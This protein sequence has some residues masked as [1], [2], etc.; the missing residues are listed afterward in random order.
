MYTKTPGFREQRIAKASSIVSSCVGAGVLLCG[1]CQPHRSHLRQ[2][3]CFHPSSCQLRSASL[4]PA[5][6]LSTCT[7]HVL[8]IPQD[9]CPP[10]ST[11]HLYWTCDLYTMRP[12]SSRLKC[13]PLSPSLWADCDLY[14]MN[15]LSSCLI[16]PPPCRS[17]PPVLCSAYHKHLVLLPQLSSYLTRQSRPDF[18]FPTMN[19]PGSCL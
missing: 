12:L 8:C 3:L 15:T 18:S 1:V 16:T 4:P 11:I 2:G 7:P 9:P 10:A 5:S 17:H 19:T 13:P 6:H 14:T